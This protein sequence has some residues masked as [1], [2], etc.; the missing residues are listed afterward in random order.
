MSFCRP[1]LLRVP[2]TAGAQDRAQR[3]VCT[4]SSDRLS[5]L[6][7]YPLTKLVTR[8]WVRFL[9]LYRMKWWKRP[10]IR[11]LLLRQDG[12]SRSG[13]EEMRLETCAKI[14]IPV[15]LCT[16]TSLSTGPIGTKIAR[17]ELY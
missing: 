3:L 15:L 9:R 14:S 16:V 12:S 13:T 5:R 6:R 11:Y 4:T 8:I 17:L 10:P 2:L 1:K 7:S